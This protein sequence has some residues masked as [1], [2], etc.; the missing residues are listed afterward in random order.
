MSDARL[1][2]TIS[3]EELIASLY[4]L[5]VMILGTAGLLYAVG[6]LT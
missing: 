4:L 5:L 2:E 6:W 3:R 1:A